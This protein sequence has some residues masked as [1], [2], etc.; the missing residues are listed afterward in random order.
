M[1]Y[2]RTVEIAVAAGVAVRFSQSGRPI[3]RYSVVLLLLVDGAWQTVRVY[4]CALEGSLAGDRSVM[5]QVNPNN[6]TPSLD[7]SFDLLARLANDLDS[8][9]RYPDGTVLVPADSSDASLAMER[10]IGERKPVAL[11][12]PDGSDVVARPPE[13]RGLR[14]FAMVVLLWGVSRL[15]RKPDQPTFVPREWVTEF[16][17]APTPRDAELV[18]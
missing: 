10:A 6:N 15:G 4:D 14:L 11:V 3:E 1:P 12:F 9:A 8:D 5:E 2:E 7:A 17:A 13:S 16:H 18:T